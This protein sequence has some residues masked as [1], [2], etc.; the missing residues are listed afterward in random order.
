MLV[1]HYGKIKISLLNTESLL[2]S[3]ILGIVSVTG[4]TECNE[5]IWLKVVT[6][7]YVCTLEPPHYITK[8]SII[9]NKLELHLGTSLM[10]PRGHD[11]ADLFH[12]VSLPC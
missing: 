8:L 9:M 4:L 12:L 1:L 2:R 6:H 10:H 11:V 7:K 5:T 3:L